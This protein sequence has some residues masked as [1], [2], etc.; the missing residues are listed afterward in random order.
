MFRANMCLCSLMIFSFIALHS[1][2]HL[3]HLESILQILQQHSLY[4]QLYK[5]SFSLL[6]LDYLGHVVS[7]FGV[8][9]DKSKIQAILERPC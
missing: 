6:E 3:T 8:A 7:R 5:C 4:T 1:V 2:A 9:M